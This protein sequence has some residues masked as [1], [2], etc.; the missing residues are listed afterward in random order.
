MGGGDSSTRGRSVLKHIASSQCHKITHS[1]PLT[2]ELT[3]HKEENRRLQ[4]AILLLWSTLVEFIK[5][6]RYLFSLYLLL[7]SGPAH[8]CSTRGDFSVLLTCGWAQLFFSLTVCVESK[9]R[10]MNWNFT[11]MKYTQ[12]IPVQVKQTSLW[13]KNSCTVSLGCF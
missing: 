3:G 11:V 8:S 9:H 1:P 2:P 7:P 12:L 13:V 10:V 4:A 5:I 6:E